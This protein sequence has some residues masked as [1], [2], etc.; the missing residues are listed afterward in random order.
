MTAGYYT[1][2]VTNPTVSSTDEEFSNYGAYS[3]QIIIETNEVDKTRLKELLDEA[4]PLTDNYG[5]KY[6]DT[7][8]AYFVATRE[9]GH[10]VYDDKTATQEEV[11]AIVAKL[12]KALLA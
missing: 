7:Y 3:V 9:E 11:D 4:D 6:I 10:N 2:E 1:F 12:E 8:W 5:I